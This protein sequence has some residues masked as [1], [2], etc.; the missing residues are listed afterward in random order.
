[1]AVKI[2]LIFLISVS[3]SQ[4]LDAVNIR[5]TLKDDSFDNV[6]GQAIDAIEK[7]KVFISNSTSVAESAISGV[8]E[9]AYSEV[10]QRIEEA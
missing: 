8:V 2:V 7:L 6:I 10:T 1:M 9:G 5:P 4:L 3:C